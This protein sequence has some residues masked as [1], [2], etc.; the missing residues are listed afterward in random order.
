MDASNNV[1]IRN[2]GRGRPARP[3]AAYGAA[4]MY[5]GVPSAAPSLL[6]V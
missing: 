4:K 3:F 6:M 1:Y 2:T 5:P